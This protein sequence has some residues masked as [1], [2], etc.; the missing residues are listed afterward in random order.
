MTTLVLP[1][2]ERI[3]LTVALRQAG[4]GKPLNLRVNPYTGGELGSMET[5]NTFAGKLHQFH[6]T[7]LLRDR[8]QGKFITLMAA[9]FLFLLSVSGLILWWP[10]KLLKFS[11]AKSG[12]V[13]NFQLHNVL[14]F[15]AS[16]F[17]LLFAVTGI[18]IH[19][20]DE[21]H[22]FLN[23]MAHEEDALI[24]KGSVAAKATARVGPDGLLTAANEAAPG[25]SVTTVQ[26]I[27]AGTPVR[28]S[29]KYPED[30]TP[31]G[32]TNLYIDPSTGE[33]LS[34]QNFRTAPL[35]T[36]IVKLWNREI[37][38]GDIFG[39]PTRIVACVASFTL[40]LLAITG[41]LIWLGRLRRRRRN[42]V[43]NGAGKDGL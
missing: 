3:A 35:G 28:I 26:N 4:P 23:K 36:R 6:T 8:Q 22:T 7:L 17:M 11:G 42:G 14:G 43:E 13:M 34:Q 32:R 5:A 39:W 30:R 29:M 12:S 19:W 10:R 25:A 9:I 41:P 38:T 2:D 21:V 37:H 1:A 33:I 18:V 27:G 40:P 15:Y 31:A 20:D 24:P 16:M